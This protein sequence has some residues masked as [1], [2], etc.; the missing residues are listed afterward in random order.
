[1]KNKQYKG[2]YNIVKNESK[3]EA[4]I[5]IYGVIGGFDWD[6]W[7][8]INTSDKFVQ[9]FK[10]I[11]ASADII[12]VKINS[13]GGNVHDGLPIYNTLKNSEKTIYTYVDGIA[14][15]MASLIALAGDKVFGYN[16]SLFMVHNASTYFFGN[17]KDIREEAEVLDKYDLALGSI[18]EEKLNVSAEDVAEKFLNYKDNYF[19][20]KEAKAEG[21][22][23]ELITSNSEGAPEDVKNMSAKDVFE[24]YAKMNFEDITPAPKKTT[25]K[26]KK[27]NRSLKNIEAVL[28]TTF[29]DSE[30]KDG[31]LLTDAEATKIDTKLADLQTATDT[32]K[33]AKVKAEGDLKT[34]KASYTSIVDQV[35]TSLKLEAEAKVTDVA[36]AFTAL[37]N[38]IAALGEQPGET[39]TTAQTQNQDDIEAMPSYVDLESSIYKIK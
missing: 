26:Q 36:G 11:E 31:V 4:T 23:D 14:Y 28:D 34:L 39:H 10:E 17:A 13:P 18:I 2:F 37:K 3:K 38:K 9:E 27:M 35:N 6:S 29:E 33:T 21:F 30:T 5:Y 32:E 7:S 20:G 1:M 19:V 25:Q 15:S 24:H 8:F 12:H 16:N 22:F